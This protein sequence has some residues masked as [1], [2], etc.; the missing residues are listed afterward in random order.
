[1]WT[2][3]SGFIRLLPVEISSQLSIH[4]PNLN[5]NLIPSHI[6]LSS[7]P[8]TYLHCLAQLFFW[9]LKAAPLW[10]GWSSRRCGRSLDE[11]TS[12]M[13]CFL[14]WCLYIHGKWAIYSEFSHYKCWFS[15]IMLVYQMVN[16]H[17]FMSF[18][19]HGMADLSSSFCQRWQEAMNMMKLHEFPIFV[20]NSS[21]L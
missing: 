17:F 21:N 18:P 16:I 2:N 15:I 8:P 12:L 10:A 20:L 4:P 14:W 19:I 11:P 6:L 3:T 1:M 7:Y 13:K 5:L 9:I